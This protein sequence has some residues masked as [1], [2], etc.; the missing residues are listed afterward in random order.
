VARESQKTAAQANSSHAVTL[1]VQKGRVNTH[2]ELTR[3]HSVRFTTAGC[4]TR[5]PACDVA[6][7]ISLNGFAID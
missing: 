5:R 6:T 2:A 7:L 1:L 3:Q 4:V